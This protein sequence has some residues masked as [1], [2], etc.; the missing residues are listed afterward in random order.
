M[1]KKK[2]KSK[3]NGQTIAL[4]RKAKHDFFIE[5]TFE[6]GMVLQGWEVKSLRA[7][8]I[9][10]KESYVLIK[11]GEAWL[12]G[13]H[14]SPLNTA[15]THI[16]PDPIRTRKLLLHRQ[17]L[18]KLIGHVE[19]RGYT[20]IPTAVYWKKGLAKLEIGLAKGKK[21][22]DKRASDK[23]RDWRRDKQRILKHSV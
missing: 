3:Q 13:A 17:E 16:N 2:S 15:S 6:A 21:Q 23:D 8:N 10:L 12:F 4:N 20:L 5:A 7:G 1:T 18:T 11:D 14:I 9:Q 22:Y 19:R